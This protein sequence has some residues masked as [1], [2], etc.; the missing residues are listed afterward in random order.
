MILS[1]KDNV[2]PHSQW[3]LLII[4]NDYLGE[5]PPTNDSWQSTNDLLSQVHSQPSGSLRGRYQSTHRVQVFCNLEENVFL[6]LTKYIMS[7]I[8][9]HNQIFSQ[10]NIFLPNIFLPDIFLPNIFLPNISPP[11]IFPANVSPPNIFPA[12]YFIFTV[13]LAPLQSAHQHLGTQDAAPQV[14]LT[15][16]FLPRIFNDEIIKPTI[17]FLQEKVF[18][19]T[20]SRLQTSGFNLECFKNL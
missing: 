3:P 14:T 8:M 18:P 7:H 16:I 11:N 15:K 9:I 20:S 5:C 17:S 13:P 4:V 10:P 19:G 12:K 6:P 1:T 2:V